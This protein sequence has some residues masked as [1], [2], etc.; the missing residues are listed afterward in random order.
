ML[1]DR[2]LT[3]IVPAAGEGKRMAPLNIELSKVMIPILGKP[4]I[5]YAIRNLYEAT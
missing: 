5:E 3:A 1:S 2:R 4:I